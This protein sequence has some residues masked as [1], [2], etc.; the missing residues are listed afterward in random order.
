MERPESLDWDARLWRRDAIERGDI[1][2]WPSLSPC[3]MRILM[4]VDL[5]GD[6]GISFSTAT[7]GLSMVLDTLVENPEFFVK[8][9]VTRAHRQADPG[10]PD[11]VTEP[12]AFHRYAPHYENFRFGPPGSAGVPEGF[13]IDDF[14]QV[15][16]FGWRGE[17][18]SSH[19]TDAELEILARWMDKGGGLL[20]M[21]DHEDLGA[22]LCSRIPRARTMRRWTAA[23]GVPDVEGP[24]RHDTLL[25][26]HDTVITFDDESDDIPQKITV[27]NYASDSFWPW[28]GLYRPFKPHPILCGKAGVI[29]ILPDHPHE[30]DIID[31]ANIDL[32]AT[33]GFGSY[34]NRPEYPGPA[35]SKVS[36]EVIA[37]A[38]VSAA[39][40]DWDADPNKG[41]ANP[42]RFPVIGAYDGHL[43][44][45]GRVVVDATWHHWF[46][47]NLIGCS[48]DLIDSE[49]MDATN[50][51]TKGFRVSNQGLQ[52]LARIQNYYRNVAIWLGPVDRKHCMWWKVLWNN[53]TRYPAAERLSPALPI[54]HLGEVALDVL[55]RQ[56]SQCSV[57]EWFIDLFAERAVL[58]EFRPDPADGLSAPPWELVEIYGIGG[59][60][61]RLLELAYD[62]QERDDP[63]D[64]YG[65]EEERDEREAQLEEEVRAAIDAGFDD[66]IAQLLDDLERSTETTRE[67][68]RVISNLRR[69]GR[70]A[71]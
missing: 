71:E 22:A 43:A 14:D 20:A 16:L 58:D 47:T 37:W 18:S 6:F 50:P 59:M 39:H 66:G 38:D 7:F 56:A 30:G 17:G 32:T 36:P 51:K 46:D 57:S 55:G 61:R 63:P 29:D 2:I 67:R 33:F 13:D 24:T 1:I 12:T 54:W 64:D 35:G 53:I 42:K 69:S 48:V 45:V 49:P 23:Q 40:T 41:P 34:S 44:G 26:G 68:M 52:A 8:F 31:E 65:T 62:V 9:D 15:W 4:L 27:R 25:A 60:T 28:R 11:P 10:K 21:G 70:E 19:L 3:R 5:A